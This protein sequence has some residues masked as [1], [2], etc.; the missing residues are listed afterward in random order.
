MTT[1]WLGR[2]GQQYR[3]PRGSSHSMETGEMEFINTVRTHE[4]SGRRANLCVH[5]TVWGE[6]LLVFHIKHDP[7]AAYLMSEKKGLKLYETQNIV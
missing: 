3:Q 7:V 6:L 5:S 1:G 4:I 2:S